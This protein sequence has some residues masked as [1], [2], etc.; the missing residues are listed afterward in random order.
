MFVNPTRRNT[1]VEALVMGTGASEFDPRVRLAVTPM[2]LRALKDHSV[3]GKKS[4][5]RIEQLRSHKRWK[6]RESVSR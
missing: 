5:G 1:A 3:R 6:K 4:L 2:R